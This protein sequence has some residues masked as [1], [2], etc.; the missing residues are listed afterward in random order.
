MNSSSKMFS[1]LRRVSSAAVFSVAFGI[2]G[3]CLLSPAVAGLG[4]GVKKKVNGDTSLTAHEQIDRFVEAKLEEK[5]MSPNADI[6]DATL[7]RRLYLNIAGRIPTIEETEAFHADSYPN[8][9]ERLIE[10][11]IGS[12][13]H[14]SNGYHF[15]ADLLRINGDLDSAVESAYS[16]WVK[17]ALR[18]NLPYD[19]MVFALVTAQG[20]YWDNGATGYY[21]R[22]RGMPLDNMSNTV[23]LFLGTRLECAQCHDHP[24]DKWTQMDYFQMAAFSYGMSSRGKNSGNRRVVDSALRE[25]S[26]EAFQSAVGIEG[27]PNMS[28]DKVKKFVGNP[29]K[30]EWLEK[31]GLS[32]KE[33]IALVEKGNEAT[34][35]INAK[36]ESM[37]AVV[38]QLYN[39]LKYSSVYENE[40]AQVKLPRDYQYSDA[41][42]LSPVAAKTMFGADISDQQLGEEGVEAYAR[43]MT[44][45]EN[46][47]FTRV[48]V[49]RLWKEV[50]GIALIEPVDELTDQTVPSH[51]ELLVYLEDLMREFDYDLQA[52]QSV[53]YK[54]RTYQR[55]ADAQEIVLGMPYYFPGPTL[56]RMS[57]EQIWDSV[58][59][60]ALP[61]AD[62]YRLRVT[63]QLQGIEKQRL[64]YESLEGRPKDEF[65]AM[66]EE[67]APE[68]EE[69]NEK[70]NGFRVALADARAKEDEV[71]FRELRNQLTDATK[72]TKKRISDVGFVYLD[73]QRDDSVL[74]ASVGLEELDIEAL[75]ELSDAEREGKALLE[76][77]AVVPTVGGEKGT[78]EADDAS[79]RNRRRKVNAKKRKRSARSALR[80]DNDFAR[81]RSL[82]DKMARASELPSPA[83]RGH[84]LR[85]FGQS[86]RE[87]I[88]NAAD[89][90][91]VP[92]ALN[93][94]NGPIV[95]A[96]TNRYA[97]FGSRLH[98]AGSVEDK[99]KLIFQAMLS[100]EPTADE[101]AL[102]GAE[103]EQ[104]GEAAY[105]GIV[106]SL[107][108]TQQFLF[109]Q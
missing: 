32:E 13:A 41:D 57:A 75:A 2:V 46:P 50:F 87:M 103:V 96:L 58:V 70:V 26:M 49:N 48:I 25:Q 83:P 34:A 42:P 5:G 10:K 100:R 52:F 95:E 15:W 89:S 102:V 21:F 35:G 4:D 99:T 3:V 101:I 24:F 20:E 94:L 29:R 88:E 23:R 16:L 62:L 85:D 79:P 93:L 82:V 9:R 77:P 90:A 17:D 108:N 60:L 45:P 30:A 28:P 18:K 39:P 63:K 107:L 1:D 92:Q 38:K 11:L 22:D 19:E 33:F 98:D 81:Y 6:D 12:E 53:L 64:I 105:E 44:S 37:K 109:V 78:S 74:L 31:H 7:V 104:S 61:E 97:V 76:L 80:G 56:R 43:W 55:A 84:F 8:K 65:I 40:K 51:P 36:A 47:T 67:L 14:V 72:S 73:Q 66:L 91:S 59:A 106:W 27:F 54:T 86:D 69:M 68:V 71:K